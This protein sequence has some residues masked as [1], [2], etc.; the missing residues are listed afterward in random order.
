M[1]RMLVMFALCVLPAL[2]TARHVGNPFT[3]KGRVYCDTCR[4]GFETDAT[5]GIPGARVRIECKDRDTLQLK[6][7]IEGVTDSTGAYNIV[8]TGDRGD[9]ICDVVL[10]SSPQSDCAEADPGRDRARVVLTGYNGL[11]SGTRFANAMGFLRTEPMSGCTEILQKY[12]E[13]DDDA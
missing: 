3:V 4:A 6:Y 2:V 13:T 5:P 11:V 9:D 7:N 12:K 8:A 1:D 10:V